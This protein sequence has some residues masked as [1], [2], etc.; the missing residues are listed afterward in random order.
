MAKRRT[1]Q[2]RSR[3]G[4]SNSTYWLIAV[5]AAL[6]LLSG[7]AGIANQ[8][9]GFI[10]LSQWHIGE[11]GD[12]TDLILGGIAIVV[13]LIV[14]AWRRL[15][16]GVG[17]RWAKEVL[18]IRS[19][20]DI[21]AMSPGRFEEFVGFLFQQ[22]GYSVKVVGQT[23]DQGIDI[24][25]HHNTLHGPVRV[26]V[27]CKRYQ[28]T[29]GQ[30]IVREFYGSFAEHAAEGY[31]VTTGTFTTPAKEWAA[32]RPLKLIDGPALMQWTDHVAQQLRHNN[33]QIP[34]FTRA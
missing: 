12:N 1:S 8:Y 10:D 28:G 32:S 22:G 33:A 4:I 7:G 26:V 15:T 16:G 13:G 6:F 34:I 14:L 2:K 3:G 29:V 20:S 5:L 30:P 11:R 23:G 21:Y 19:L 25:M 24:E 27:Q 17:H 18:G 31:L 9:L